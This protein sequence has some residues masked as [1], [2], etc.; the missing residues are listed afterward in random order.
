M[1]EIKWRSSPVYTS[2]NGQP[3]L[4]IDIWSKII[5]EHRYSYLYIIRQIIYQQIQ[6]YIIVN[7]QPQMIV[8]N[9]ICWRKTDHLY[10]K[11]T[12][13]VYMST[14]AKQKQFNCLICVIFTKYRITG[15]H[16]CCILFVWQYI[17][18]NTYSNN[19][20]TYQYN[21]IKTHLISSLLHEK[22]LDTNKHQLSLK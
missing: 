14:I 15:D 4:Y 2:V 3:D 9:I 13:Q 8:T 6:F 10:L 5:S 12:I 17:Y 19:I 18:H 16:R 1:F 11:F 7:M 21:I 22:S 20:H